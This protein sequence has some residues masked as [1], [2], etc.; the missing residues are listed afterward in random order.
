M[1][2]L[3]V[4][5]SLQLGMLRV[6]ECWPRRPRLGSRSRRCPPVARRSAGSSRGPSCDTR[7]PRSLVPLVE[8]SLNALRV[9]SCNPGI[10]LVLVR[11]AA[12]SSARA[13]GADGRPSRSA[14]SCR[15][16][17]AELVLLARAVCARARI[18]S[19]WSLAR[20][21]F[22]RRRS[23]SSIPLFGYFAGS[24][25]RRA[26]R[27]AERAGGRAGITSRSRSPRSP[28]RRCSSTGTP[29]RA[30]GS[31]PRAVVGAPPSSRSPPSL[32]RSTAYALGPALRLSPRRTD[33]RVCPSAE[34]APHRALR[35]PLSR[36]RSIRQ[37]DRRRR[38]R[39]RVSLRATRSRCSASRRPCRC[40]PT[41]SRPP[42]RSSR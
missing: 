4:L 25:L 1:T 22:L 6:G 20:I 3:V 19:A 39:A 9:R 14:C 18:R 5:A 28:S 32:P 40:T 30:R 35:A 42:P 2:P 11:G 29:A 41:S 8:M 36:R 21:Y 37:G 7:C 13:F 27:R 38:D 24:P 10:G 12:R 16:A 33:D 31:P 34:R 15:G 23:S 17:R 26:R